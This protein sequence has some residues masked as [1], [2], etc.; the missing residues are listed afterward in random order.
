MN[1]ATTGNVP[2]KNSGVHTNENSFATIRETGYLALQMVVETPKVLFRT[3]P[4][5]NGHL[6]ALLRDAREFSWH[7]CIFFICLSGK[8]NL[9]HL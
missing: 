3:D 2:P 8:S 1:K 5:P 7:F 6:E 9:A 4:Y